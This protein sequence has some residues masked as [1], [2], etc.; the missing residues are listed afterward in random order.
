MARLRRLAIIVTVVT[1]L[2]PLLSACGERQ[3]SGSR[4]KGSN[5][6]NENND[7][8]HDRGSNSEKHDD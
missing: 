6:N 2:T 5:Q 8:D 1:L 3:E 4:E 7:K